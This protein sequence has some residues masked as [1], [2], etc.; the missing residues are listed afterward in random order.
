MV[1]THLDGGNLRWNEC[2]FTSRRLPCSLAVT[3]FQ[4][5]IANEFAGKRH[6]EKSA[7]C[8]RISVA[9]PNQ[10]HHVLERLERRGQIAQLVTQKVYRLHQQP[11]APSLLV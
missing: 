1:S 11:R 4:A 8:R 6:R 3:P 5:V 10:A 7:S 2:P 9:R